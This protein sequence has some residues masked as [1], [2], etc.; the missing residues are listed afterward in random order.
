MF[1]SIRRF[2]PRWT[3]ILVMAVSVSIL[4]TPGRGQDPLPLPPEDA[5]AALDA[6]NAELG[7]D[8]DV[9]TSGPLHEA[10]ARPYNSDPQPGVVVPE[11]PPEPIDEIPPEVAPEGDDMV[12]M[13]GYWGWDP[14]E[15]R[16]IWISGVWRSVPPGQR[17]VPG[18]WAE[19]EGG[20]QWVSGFWTSS[21]SDQVTYLPQ[22]PENLDQGPASPA[23]GDDYYW[24]PGCWIWNTTQYQWR[25]GFWSPVYDDWVWVPAQYVWTPY[26]YVFSGGFWDRRLTRRGV[27]FAP[28]Y[29]HRPIFR[30]PGFFYRPSFVIRIGPALVHWFVSPRYHHYYYGN[31]YSSLVRSSFLLPWYSYRVGVRYYDPLFTYYRVFYRK[32]GIDFDHRLR[33]WHRYFHDHEDHRPPKHVRRYWENGRRWDDDRIE[34]VWRIA[35][36]LDEAVREGDQEVRFRPLDEPRHRQALEAAEALRRAQRTRNQLEQRGDGP[37]DRGGRGGE[38]AS[39]RGG[40]GRFDA[41]DV[42]RVELP[43]WVSRA[44]RDRRAAAD[45]RGRRGA[46]GEDRRDVGQRGGPGGRETGVPGGGERRPSDTLQ[47]LLDGRRGTSPEG[48]R[49]SLPDRDPSV[50][51]PSFDRPGGDDDARRGRGGRIGQPGG[52]ETGVPGGIRRPPNVAPP[53]TIRRGG[54]NVERGTPR[55]GTPRVIEQPRIPDRG[56]GRGGV[57]PRATVDPRQRA[58]EQSLRERVMRPG[59]ETIRRPATPRVEPQQRGQPASPRSVP[60][61]RGSESRRRDSAQA[62]VLRGPSR[63]VERVP[64]ARGP[65]PSP[66]STRPEF[67][68][69]REAPGQRI[70]PQIDRSPRPQPRIEASPR[71]RP[72]PQFVMPRGGPDRE[73]SARRDFGR[74]TPEP[75]IRSEGGG[76]S[77]SAEF[78]QRFSES[79]SRSA[80]SFGRERGG[81]ERP[82]RGRGRDRD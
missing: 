25:P 10:F 71:S 81:R 75:M 36:P 57:L 13:P 50:R 38:L 49:G 77:R 82:S 4:M 22:P 78:R 65:I 11:M 2:G 18:Y 9:L 23:P 28:V 16:F 80:V 61:V 56:G 40:R 8:I 15:E 20:A 48:R 21:D 60:N 17:W 1:T 68:I 5:S 74:R 35:R 63:E 46:A 12:W 51:R 67:T 27:L 30:R 44:D 39:G 45:T 42:R 62:P 6:S 54:E 3:V 37:G 7:E 53:G 66:R 76:G 32:R 55:A 31:Y 69:R 14:E 79:R 73:S 29:F 34:R 26:G 70:A 64:T 47:R 43:S 24:V 52:Q 72:Q 33:S 41:D 58:L 59:A 19:V